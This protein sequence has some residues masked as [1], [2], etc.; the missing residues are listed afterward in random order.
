MPTSSDDDSDAGSARR[1]LFV[2][3]LCFT[4][5]AIACLMLPSWDVPAHAVPICG[6]LGVGLILI[7]R[8]VPSAWVRRIESL[9]LGWP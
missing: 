4:G 9:F 8:F 7:A 3:G 5:L 2:L 1:F 6:T